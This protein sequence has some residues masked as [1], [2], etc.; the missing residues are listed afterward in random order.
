MEICET[1]SE[2]PEGSASGGSRTFVKIACGATSLPHG[3]R[4]A[5]NPK[6]GY[7]FGARAVFS[8]FLKKGSSRNIEYKSRPT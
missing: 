2:R 8:L 5:P 4:A 6:Y 1:D 3:S 7:D